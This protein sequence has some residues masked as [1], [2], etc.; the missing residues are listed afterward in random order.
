MANK[1]VYIIYSLRFQER[2]GYSPGQVIGAL[3][4][5]FVGG[6]Y[7]IGKRML[8][9]IYGDED[10][11]ETCLEQLSPYAVEE[12]TT[13]QALGWADFAIP[14]NTQTLDDPGGGVKY[15][16]PAEIV[17]NRVSKPTSDTPYPTDIN[18]NMRALKKKKI[19]Y[20]ARKAYGRKY[21]EEIREL[22]GMDLLPAGITNAV[23]TYMTSIINEINSCE[24]AIANATTKAE[25][26]A[27]SATWPE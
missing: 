10:D 1:L 22:V 16:G 15:V 4:L 20:Q 8:G 6:N 14:I 9:Y 2:K 24:T 21:E 13:A 19:R 25:L 12:L 27:V 7:P 3:D 17:N 26:D 23:K 11:V 5:V 18:D